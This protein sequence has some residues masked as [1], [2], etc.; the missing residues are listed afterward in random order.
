MKITHQVNKV[1]N[2]E[3]RDVIEKRLLE[4][5]LIKDEELF[6][7][8]CFCL[9]TANF[10]ADKCVEI[11]GKIG[12]GFHDWSEERLALELKAMGHRFWPQRAQRIVLARELKKDILG[13]RD[14]DSK[15]AR[16]FLVKNVKGLGLKESSHFLRNV[17]VLDV[18]IIDFHIV[19]LLVR[20]GLI[21]RPSSKSITPR[22]YLEIEDSLR[23]L[24]KKLSMNLAELD[25]YLWYI[26][27]GNIL[28]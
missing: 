28:K 4:F 7:E 23:V 20:E 25:L 2:S 1:R 15:V 26:E 18:A 3:V 22:K 13:I 24:G 19:D 8:L 6:E 21:E 10:R 17:G 5:A 16:D 12:D 9:M 27:T 14:L 11:Q